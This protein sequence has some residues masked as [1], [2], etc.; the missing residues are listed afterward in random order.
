MHGNYLCTHNFSR[1]GLGE[2]ML[3]KCC[4]TNRSSITNTDRRLADWLLH[5]LSFNRMHNKN[6]IKMKQKQNTH[7]YSHG[8]H[9]GGIV[10]TSNVWVHI[11]RSNSRREKKRENELDGRRVGCQA[12][13]LYSVSLIDGLK[14][15]A[16]P[17]LN[18]SLPFSSSPSLFLTAVISPSDSPSIC[19]PHRRRIA[20][21]T[22]SCSFHIEPWFGGTAR[23]D[24]IETTSIQFSFETYNK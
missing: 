7:L 11:P 1:T 20:V 23:P 6:E 12:T 14:S 15:D 8:G 22:C 3:L 17:W 21:Q 16:D 13:S 19:S 9:R 2:F 5:S 24:R 18:L 4:I 10:L